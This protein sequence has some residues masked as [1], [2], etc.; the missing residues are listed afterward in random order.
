MVIPLT[1]KN[2]SKKTE[3]ATNRKIDSIDS[4][5]SSPINDDEILEFVFNPQYENIS[6]DS[7]RPPMV[8][9][10]INVNVTNK[11]EKATN[12]KIRRKNRAKARRKVKRSIFK[13]QTQNKGCRVM[14]TNADS[15]QNKKDELL[16]RI[17]LQ[18]PDIIAI[19]ETKCKNSKDN[20]P[21]FDIPNFDKFE[22]IDPK[23]GVALFIN[24][25]YN[26]RS[27]DILNS[28]KYQEGIWCSF[29]SKENLKILIGCLYRSPNSDNSNNQLLNELLKSNEIS[30]YNKVCIMGDFN[31]P[32]LKWDGTDLF[33]QEED[34]ENK[35]NIF[36]EC[37]RDAFL[38]QNVQKPTRNRENQR[39]NILDLI[40]TSDDDLITEIEH[41]DPLGKSDHQVLMFNMIINL[42]DDVTSYRHKLNLSKG[43]YSNMREEFRNLNWD[44]LL[45]LN[46][47]EMWTCFSDRLKES[48][49]RNIP[50]IKIP[51]KRKHQPT[52]MSKKALRRIK[53][54]H[55]LFKRFLNSN[56]GIAYRKYVSMRNKCKK[57]IK[58]AK[59]RH[60]RKIGEES[61]NNPKLFWKYVQEQNK[62]KQGISALKDE[63]GN[64]KTTDKD[65]ADILN[66]YFASVYTTDGTDIPNLEESSKSNGISISDLKTTPSEIEK[67][68]TNLDP[69]KA[70]GPDNIPPK[71]LKEL[72]HEISLPL[73]HIF[74]KSLESGKIP[75][76]WKTAVVTAIHK[77]GSK[78]EAGNYRP[79]SLTCILCKVLESIIRD[80]IVGHFNEN[81][82]YAECQHGFRNKRSCISQLLEVIED[83]TVYFDGESVDIV[84]LDFRKAF[85]TVPHQRLLVKLKSYGITGQLYKWVEDFLVGRSQKVKVGNTI[86]NRSEVTSGIPQG[87]ILGP[88]LFTIFIND[89]PEGLKNICKIFAD[90]TKV[91]GSSKESK[92]IQEDIDKLQEWSLKWNLYFNV[93]K[94]KVM[95][96]GKNNPETKYTMKKGENSSD[97]ATCEEEKDLGVTFDRNLNFNKHIELAI[98]KANKMLGLIKRTFSYL[99]KDI[100]LKLYKSLVRPHLEYGN[101][102]WNRLL[103]KH[104]ISIEKVQRRATKILKQCKHLTYQER[105][106]YLDLHSLKGR[107]LRG[108]L[109]ETYKM[110]N[111]FTD[112]DPFK[113]FEKSKTDIT[114]NS[115]NKVFIKDWRIKKIKNVYSYRV[116]P[117]WNALTSDIKNAQTT[118]HFKNLLDGNKIW[119]KKFK[120]IDVYGVENEFLPKF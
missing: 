65:K 8:I 21:L 103:K 16:T 70:Q 52:W 27:V 15:L 101:I 109:I 102:I 72:S 44:H 39:A 61:K 25:S 2:V 67:R 82:L 22:N 83:L 116:A 74:N 80:A 120:E 57:E 28:N 97:I 23:R 42:D 35:E 64:L 53:K 69:S 31:Y 105:L 106:E 40:L 119:A 9:P 98:G 47:N 1:N 117:Y 38:I 17:D 59:K 18:K 54:K 56:S 4:T 79:V 90:D 11:P 86:S 73:S 50:E 113:F 24:N 13:E 75:D 46:I 48:M 6:P 99:T 3:K 19:T 115:E 49:Y 33:N 71:I 76:E 114:R 112:T 30:K 89:L 14:Y 84:Y 92:S 107:R 85:D 95:H 81:K 94:C 62:T 68:L 66:N 45:E 26:A 55:K 32:K 118:N 58:K 51:S 111:G 96:I 10:L 108:D 7:Y 60:E 87:S 43:N 93:E 12:R 36:V 20:N 88:I 91:Y 110:F 5:C 34:Q 63:N 104:S 29:N 37:L 100:F 78:N 77:K 41:M